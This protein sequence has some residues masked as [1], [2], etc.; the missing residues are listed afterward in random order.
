MDDTLYTEQY[1]LCD[2]KFGAFNTP[3]VDLSRAIHIEIHPP[4][5]KVCHLV[6]DTWHLMQLP[7]QKVLMQW[8]GE[9]PSFAPTLPSTPTKETIA[10]I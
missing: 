7:L 10:Q 3:L 1:L 2:I 5:V 9:M 4:S 8:K 6:V